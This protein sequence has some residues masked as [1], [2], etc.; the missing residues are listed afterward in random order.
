MVR[1]QIELMADGGMDHWSTGDRLQWCEINVRPPPLPCV[2]SGARPSCFFFAFWRHERRHP[3]QGSRWASTA[4]VVA[5]GTRR[6]NLAEL[7]AQGLGRLRE[8]VESFEMGG[9]DACTAD[10]QSLI[11]LKM[12]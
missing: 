11:F 5:G 8:V 7:A 9:C 3:P 10:G 1:V 2:C 6:S 12:P 4:K